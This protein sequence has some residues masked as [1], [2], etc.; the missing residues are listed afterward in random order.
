MDS[1]TD[2]QHFLYFADDTID[3]VC[4]SLQVM[5]AAGVGGAGDAPDFS[6]RVNTLKKEKDR[7][8][9]DLRSMCRSRS[10]RITLLSDEPLTC[11]RVHNASNPALAR[12]YAR[13]YERGFVLWAEGQSAVSLWRGLPKFLDDNET[14][15]L[16]IPLRH[17]ELAGDNKSLFERRLD[18]AVSRYF[19]GIEAEVKRICMGGEC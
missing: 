17:F 15:R 2:Y 5:L 18:R 12:F 8:L 13:Y 10:L 9:D 19:P 3:K 4:Q 1:G 6:A 11:F 7:V 14:D 16:F